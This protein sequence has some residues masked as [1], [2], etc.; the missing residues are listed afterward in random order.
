MKQIFYISLIIVNVFFGAEKQGFS[1]NNHGNSVVLNRG[2]D[3]QN[4]PKLDRAK[5]YL[6]KGEVKAAISNYGQFMGW[7]F[8]PNGLWGQYTYIP[9]LSFIA[10][11]PGHAY[12]SEWSNSSE[13]E[14]AWEKETVNNSI[15]LGEEFLEIWVG[16]ETIYSAWVN[17]DGTDNFIGIVYNTKDDRGDIAVERSSYKDFNLVSGPQWAIDHSEEKIYLYLGDVNLNPNYASSRIGLAY[18]WSIRPA[19]KERVQNADGFFLDQYDYGP[20]HDAWSDDDAYVY[21]GA[22]FAESN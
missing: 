5:G 17:D 6:L 12:S 10:G 14:L 8:Q 11:V 7:G 19:F 20:D 15:E 9:D 4:S 18:P 22:T 21:Y 16:N 3:I 13:E 2:G 1:K